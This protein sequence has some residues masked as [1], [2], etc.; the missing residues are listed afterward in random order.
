VY[1]VDAAIVAPLNELRIYLNQASWT[2]RS[3]P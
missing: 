1:V 2:H 3:H